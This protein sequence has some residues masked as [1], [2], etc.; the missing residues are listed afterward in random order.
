M[1]NQNNKE[2]RENNRSNS[3][4][5]SFHSNHQPLDSAIGPA[6]TYFLS[7]DDGETLQEPQQSISP[8]LIHTSTI[9]QPAKQENQSATTAAPR[10]KERFSFIK[11]HFSTQSS[12]GE[13]NTGNTNSNVPVAVLPS[14]QQTKTKIPVHIR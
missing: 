6:P 14:T 9:A 10:G 7:D 5:S 11:R 2:K 4:S 1:M 13:T 8:L 12:S 3:S